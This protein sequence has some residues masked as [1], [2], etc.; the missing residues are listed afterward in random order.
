MIDRRTLL[1]SGAAV[2]VGVG[3]GVGA[4]GCGNNVVAAPIANVLVDDDPGSVTYGQIAIPVAMYP[5]LQPVGGAITLQLQSLPHN[6]VRT[7]QPPP[8]GTIL[9]VHYDSQ[10]FA[11][12]SATCPHASC[13]LG[14]SAHDKLVECPCH[15]STF[16]AAATPGDMSTCAG[17]VVHLPARN[18]LD[19]WSATY[20]PAQNLVTV[21]LNLIMTCGTGVLPPVIN[22]TVTVPLATYPA[23][24]MIGGS[25]LGQPKGL[26]DTLIV[27]R[28]DATT[29][30]AL[31]SVCTHL[32][33]AVGY[34]MTNKDLECPCHGSRFDLTGKVTMSPAT[35][36]L[37]AYTATFDGMAVVIKVA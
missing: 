19:A 3:V 35:L 14:Y 23:L 36:P 12:L 20:D 9:L 34:S 5:Q 24:A 1:K 6:N 37:K 18:A 33:C 26:A 21:D 27:V 31:S 8:N 2:S 7:W 30:V 25:V 17:Q 15:G 28:V 29:A 11:A 16:R 13:P 10:T 4:S 22:G 32:Q